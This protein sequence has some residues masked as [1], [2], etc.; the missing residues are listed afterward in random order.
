MYIY[1]HKYIYIAEYIYIY[2]YICYICTSC[3][4]HHVTT[5][6]HVPKSISCHKAIVVIT[7]RQNCFH[8]NIYAMLI[9]FS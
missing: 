9:L 6:H 7:E 5:V 8:D 1:V 3:A 4:Q 2:I